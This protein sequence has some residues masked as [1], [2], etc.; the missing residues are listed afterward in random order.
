MSTV[1][2][3]DSIE[4]S[5]IPVFAQAAAGYAAGPHNRFP[6][7]N[8]IVARFPHLAAIGRLL[9]YAVNAQ[10]K[11]DILDIETGDATPE[12]FPDWYREMEHLGIWN[13]GAYANKSTWDNFLT[14]VLEKAGIHRTRKVIADWTGH[15]H[16]PPGYNMC[17]W[18]DR[19]PNNLND[20]ISLADVATMFPPQNHPSIPARGMFHAALVFD[21]HNGHW[22]VHPRP[23]VNVHLASQSEGWDSVQAQLDPH[24]G[25][26]RAHSMP[27]NAPPLGGK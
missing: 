21:R 19:G 27:K 14:R 16:L 5:Q 24:T 15:P 12:Q 23:G 4:A 9:S 22:T 20:D 1:T 26:W 17:Q 13:P 6:D 2:V 25:E 7:Y 11:A 18:T 10:I 8:E 3:Y